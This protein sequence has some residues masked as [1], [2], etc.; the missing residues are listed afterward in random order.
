MNELKKK[1]EQL[2]KIHDM[3]EE[4]VS[5][6]KEIIHRAV[7]KTSGHSRKA[8]SS[9]SLHSWV[10]GGGA[11]EGGDGS[12]SASMLRDLGVITETLQQLENDRRVRDASRVCGCRRRVVTDEW[13]TYRIKGRRMISV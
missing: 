1:L 2:Q 13:E 5:T 7:Q 11:G 4:E 6:V 8:N 9:N 3:M 12:G 10:T